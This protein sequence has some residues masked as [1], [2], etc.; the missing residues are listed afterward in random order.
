METAYYNLSGG[1]NQATTKTELG[2]NTK[3]VFWSDSENVEILQNKGIIKQKGNVLF[4]S[5]PDDD[6]VTGMYQL[7]MDDTYKLIITTYTGKIYIY[8]KQSGILKLLEKTLKGKRPC[9]ASFL[10][11]VVANTESD[12]LF[13]IKNNANYDIEDCNFKDKS[14]NYILGGVIAI[15]RGRVW[16]AKE[17]T[18]YYS[19]LGTYNDF[20]TSEDAGYI[21]DFH[22]DTFDIIALKSYKDYLAIYKKDMVYLLSGITPADFSILPFANKG[23]YASRAIVNVNNKQYFLSNGIFPLEQGELNQIQLGSEITTNIKEEFDKFDITRIDETFCLHYETKNQIWYFFPYASNE[24]F[25][26]IW[27]NDYANKC[28]YKRV[29]PQNITAAA[30]FNGNILTADNKGKIYIENQN[31]TF[32]GEPIKFMWK[33][34]FFSIGDAFHRKMIDEFYFILDETYD[35]NFNFTVYKDYDS[36]Y[37]DDPEKIYAVHFE[38]FIWADDDMSETMPCCWGKDDESVPIWSVNRN[39]IE[40]AEI[41]ESNYSI[42]LCIE[43]N[44][45]THSC[46]II[47][48]QFREIY[49]DD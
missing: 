29:V 46:A 27:I 1:I 2:L 18:L 15:F 31:N 24:F 38:H 42:Q 26:T 8:N 5:I 35:N 11:G 6:A 28:W 9:F 10:N 7:S 47:G 23:C 12:E 32:N 43:G 40:K 48:L 21:N 13:Y 20:T 36:S 4:L 22:T 17:S 3:K 49:N 19:A 37:A 16:I 30:L 41:S 39:A 44:E 14:D 33:S 25:Q 45:M 34:P